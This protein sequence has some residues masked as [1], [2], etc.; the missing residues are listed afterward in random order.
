MSTVQYSETSIKVYFESSGF[1]HQTE[2]RQI[3]NVDL[4]SGRVHPVASV[5]DKTR[6]SHYLTRNYLFRCK[7][8]TRLGV[9]YSASPD[10]GA[11]RPKHGVKIRRV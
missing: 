4:N 1:E 6:Q 8:C 7:Y 9:L 5:Y 2:M 11:S 3:T 10:D